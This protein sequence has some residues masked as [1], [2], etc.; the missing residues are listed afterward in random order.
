M[1]YWL[2]AII[3]LSYQPPPPSDIEHTT[4]IPPGPPSRPPPSTQSG[5]LFYQER[6]AR[7]MFTCHT[8]FSFTHL[9]VSHLPAN[10]FYQSG[11][12][13]FYIPG[14][15]I[16][17][18]LEA[19]ITPFSPSPSSDNRHTSYFLGARPPARPLLFKLVFLFN[20]KYDL[21]QCGGSYHTFFSFLR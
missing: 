17:I 7:G 20:K 11:T 12:K 14:K 18:S 9:L 3:T 16:K 2:Q 13:Y 6:C 19:V 5:T 1:D 10:S 4:L 21:N 8:S 15:I